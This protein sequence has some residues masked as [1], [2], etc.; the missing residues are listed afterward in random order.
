[1]RRAY[2]RRPGRGKSGYWTR[3]NF[4]GASRIWD[5][6]KFDSMDFALLCSYTHPDAPTP[7]LDLVTD[8]YVWV[9]FFDDDFLDKFKRCPDQAGAK[10]YLDRLPLFMP[11]DPDGHM[12]QSANPV[13]RGLADLWSRTV[14]SK[15]P[16]WRL[17][18]HEST[19]NLLNESLWELANISER[20]VPNPIEYIEMRRKVG[21]APWSADLVEHAVCV[22]IPARVAH[23]RPMRVLKDAFADS[24]HLRNDLFSY[25]REVEDEGEL[26]NGVLVVQRFLELDTQA[27][28]NL[29]NDILTSRLQQFENTVFSELPVLFEE[30][31]LDAA[32]RR[33]VLSYVKGLQDWQ[34]GGH[35]W[36]LRSSRY[37]NANARPARMLGAVGGGLTGL[38]T[39]AARIGLSRSALGLRIR[40]HLHVPYQSVGTLKIPD[41]SMPFSTRECPHLETA[42][43]H[44]GRWARRMGMLDALPGAH[45]LGIWDEAEF[46]SADIAGYA[47]LIDP[48]ASAPELDLSSQWLTW[49]MYAD[50]YFAAVFG[51]VRD[52]AGARAFNKRLAL[53]LPVNGSNAPMPRNAVESGLADLWP[54]TSAALPH[55]VRFQ[56]GENILAMTGSWLW[57]LANRIQHRIPDPVDYVEMRRKTFGA[58]F[59]M[60]LSQV[61]QQDTLPRELLAARPMRGLTDATADVVSLTNDMFSYR[62]DVEREGELNNG[63]LVVGAFLDCNPQQGIDIIGDLIAC[64]VGQFER[65]AAAELPLLCED[66]KLNP[67]MRESVRSCVH[68]WRDC[69]AGGLRW[70]A[71]TGRY[72]K[73]ERR[74]VT[75]RRREFHAPTGLGTSAA[76]IVARASR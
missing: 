20:R 48:D 53:F 51:H 39:A 76:R 73:R 40:A 33:N 27:A 71:E 17:R 64:R 58:A 41:V 63:V 30:H 75:N 55:N 25:Q 43:R 72:R 31:R 67:E 34:S 70:H 74:D 29:V 14:S 9:F 50:D 49:K 26:A 60:G 59:V 15:S 66:A 44:T 12:P 7:E 6:A 52:I 16:N 37:M 68:H 46:I 24:V 54:R 57:E 61:S 21:G 42:R 69:M 3:S 65:I 10:K 5:E 32:E 56:F 23:T 13:E 47:A 45:G 4:E 19:T 36:H 38:G 28:A 62:K 35:E 22:E 2:T 18:F 8:W 1:M 11:L